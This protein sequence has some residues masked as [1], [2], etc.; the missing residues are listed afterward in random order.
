MKKEKPVKTFSVGGSRSSSR[1]VEKPI[2]PSTIPYAE[3]LLGEG[4]TA[5][6]GIPGVKLPKEVSDEALWEN[7]SERLLESIRPG[8]AARGL[9]TSGVGQEAETDA[10]QD[11]AIKFSGDE[12]DRALQRSEFERSGLTS[13]G[14]QLAQLMA[15]ILGQGTLGKSKSSATSMQASVLG[16]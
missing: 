7:M 16:G 4:I 13:Y 1:S 10:L 6:R 2:A 5:A 14:D 9:L 15:A 11:L 3:P 8:F 12:F